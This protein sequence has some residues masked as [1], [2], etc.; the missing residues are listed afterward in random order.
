MFRL[1]AEGLEPWENKTDQHSSPAW[2][3]AAALPASCRTGAE[4]LQRPEPG[5]L[6]SILLYDDAAAPIEARSVSDQ[7]GVVSRHCSIEALGYNLLDQR[8]E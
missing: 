7:R 2:P 1:R 8:L 5:Q 4:E 3:A 6:G